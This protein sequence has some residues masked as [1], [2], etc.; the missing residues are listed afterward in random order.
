MPDLNFSIKGVSEN[1]TKFVAEARNFKIIID[2]PP[3]LGGTDHGANPVEYLLA[4]YAGCLNV[5]GH[6][7]AGELGFKLDKLEIEIN[8]DL[9]PARL[10]GTS[11]DERAGFKNIQVTV[12][13][14]ADISAE[15][16]QKWIDAV[17]NRCPINDN[18]R[19]ITPV[20]ITILNN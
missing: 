5:M 16:L 1:P 17:E 10:F 2:E 6:L 20:G 7:I 13:P 11:F 19:A 9:N 18:L 14:F 12:K 8:G 15:L 3:T 4:S